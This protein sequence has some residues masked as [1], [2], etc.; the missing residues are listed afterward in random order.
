MA[1]KIR[2][3][4]A[5][6]L[7]AFAFF[8]GGANALLPDTLSIAGANNV[9][10]AVNQNLALPACTATVEENN[11]VVKLLGV[12]PVKKVALNVLETDEVYPGGMAF[13]VK[14]FTE[15]VL[16]VGL[17][18]VVGFSGT[19]CPAREAGI[20][21]GDVV[22]SINGAPVS[23]ANALRDTVAASEG[24]ALLMEIKRDGEVFTTTL[25]PVLCDESNSYLA[26]LWV[27]DSTAGIGTVTYVNAKD[28]SF[29][30]LG[31]GICDSDTGTLMPLGKAVVVDVEINGV[32]RGEKGAPGE[33]KGSFG[34]IKRGTIDQNTETGVYGTLAELPSELKNPMPIGLSYEIKEGKA[35][36]YTTLEGS[37]PEKFEIEIEKI[38]KNSGNTKNMM[39]KVTDPKLLK[40][41][42]GIVQ[43]MSGSPI[44]Q[45][46][47]LVAAVTHVLIDD[48]TRGYGIFIEN[49]LDTAYG[50]DNAA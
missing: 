50:L 26:G 28:L 11:A 45:N 14:F 18:D 31:H 34:K 10:T 46:G 37:I 17:N 6:A 25:Y 41:T 15:G 44:I 35:F 36:I 47:K 12:L 48:P 32:R 27:R 9:K 23:S 40:A 22:L 21:K 38:Y 19:F 13:G 1:K 30:G 4:A 42:G 7:L 49:M 24:N 43:G 39:I 33:L 3:S 8:F 5:A 20:R 2:I 16:V 29:G